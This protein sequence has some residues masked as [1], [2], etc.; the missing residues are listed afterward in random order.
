MLLLSCF[1]NHF[2]K[3][4]YTRCYPVLSTSYQPHPSPGLVHSASVVQQQH[5]DPSK[6]RRNAKKKLLSCS[7]YQL[8]LPRVHGVHDLSQGYKTRFLCGLL[9]ANHVLLFQ[10]TRNLWAPSGPP[11]LSTRQPV[12]SAA[13]TQLHLTWRSESFAEMNTE[14]ACSCW[15][16]VWLTFSEFHGVWRGFIQ[17]TLK[18]CKH[19]IIYD[20]I[21]MISPSQTTRNSPVFLA[22]D[23][24][25]GDQFIGKWP[26]ECIH[27]TRLDAS[28]STFEVVRCWYGETRPKKNQEHLQFF[29]GNRRIVKE[30][31][32]LKEEKKGFIIWHQYPHQQWD[33]P[34]KAA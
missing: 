15:I 2:L 21:I 11:W 12:C 30:H 29:I 31:W 4:V 16:D 14:D 25:P 3:R 23:H 17:I 5:V 6:P 24:R 13:H 26:C 9:G 33:R 7:W 19:K 20:I 18:V 32:H 22:C 8:E 28:S 1:W 10:E 27:I 34:M